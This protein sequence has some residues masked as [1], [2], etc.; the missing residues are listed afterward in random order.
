MPFDHLVAS[1]PH[2][3]AEHQTVWLSPIDLTRTTF[4][5]PAAQ[6][7]ARLPR[8]ASSVLRQAVPLW[9]TDDLCCSAHRCVEL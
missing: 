8:A 5:K 2:V 3:E 7:L 1:P 9:L 6:D 4:S